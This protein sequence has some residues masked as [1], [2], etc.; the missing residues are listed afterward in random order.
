MPAG[1]AGCIP[2]SEHE[3]PYAEA[4]GL[5]GRVGRLAMPQASGFT[6]VA[7]AHMGA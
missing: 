3:L 2:S 5:I 6:Y 1:C 4:R 7:P